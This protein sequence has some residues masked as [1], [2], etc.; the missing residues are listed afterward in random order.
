M[1]EQNKKQ[2][3]A[4]VANST[5]NIYNFRLNLIDKFLAEGMD[6]VVIA[7]VDEYLTYKEQYPTVR[8]YG[9][10]MMDRDSTNP[11]KDIFL[12]LELVRKYKKIKPDIILHFTNKP[13][14]YGG[15]AAKIVGIKS[16]AVVTGLGYAFINKGLVRAMMTWLYRISGGFHQKFIFENIEDRELFAEL[17]IVS[18]DRAVSVKGC[19]V[20]T[21]WY[22]PYPNGQVKDKTIFTFIGR[23]LY[24]K[25][26]R[27]FVEAARQIKANLQ[28][29]AFWVVGELDAENPATIDKDDL[30]KWVEEDI[31]YYHGFVK[32][33]RPIIAESDCIVLPSYREGLPRI[34]LEGM[35]M[36]KPVITTLS[37]GCSET[38][39]VGLNGF[40]VEIRNV[41]ALKEAFIHFM[42]LSYQQ[43]SAM[44]MAGR[45]K[46][47][48]EFDDKKIAI[49]I[50]NLVD[51][52]L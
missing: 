11:I 27:E 35:S 38:V 24:D 47:I 1:R 46:A 18:G 23:L 43:R 7:P 42:H 25:G 2:T 51:G 15:I 3:I 41:E 52:Q 26:I 29:V 32:D 50:F 22:H 21:T 5:W 30:I 36:S 10:R 33:V 4:L 48:N 16:I 39:D 19:G 40:L 28:D 9:L 20:D 12:L 31:I 45:D 8:H 14:I 34:I 49:E 6:V 13:N 17:G 37:A 44:G